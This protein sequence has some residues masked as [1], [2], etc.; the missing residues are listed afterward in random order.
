MIPLDPCSESPEWARSY[1]NLR[2]A[3]QKATNENGYDSHA[4]RTRVHQLFRER[5]GCPPHD[6]QVDVTEAMLLGL[7]SI[8]IAGTG[9]GKTMPFMMPLLL[10]LK[11]KCIIISPLK[12]LQEDQASRFRRMQ[13]SATA[14]N[15]DSWSRE[16]QK[17]LEDNQYQ[18]ILA[19]P[20]MCIK[21]SDFRRT[22]TNSNFKD[23]VAIIIDEAHCIGQWGGDFRTAY[24][25]LAKLRAFFPPH[26]PVLATTATATLQTLRDIRLS[27]GIDAATSFF[28]NLGNDRPNI[29]YHVHRMNSAID[30]EALRPHITREANVSRQDDIP[31]QIIF[32]NAVL[33]SQILTRT[34]RS[35]FPSSLHNSIAYLHSHRSKRAKHQIMEAFRKGKVRILIATEAA[36]MGADIPDI[37]QVIQFGVPSSLAVWTQRAGRAGR[38]ANI[39]ARAILLVEKSMFE[40]TKK[41][42]RKAA[43]PGELEDTFPEELGADEEEGSEVEL[44]AENIESEWKK[45]VED[46][47]RRWIETTG[48]RRDIADTYFHNPRHRP[49]THLC[50]DNCTIMDVDSNAVGA[51]AAE[52]RP[53]TPLPT[54][55]ACNSVHST[56]SKSAN[57]NGKR[58]MTLSQSQARHRQGEHLK[59]ARIALQNWR[60]NVVHHHYTPGPFTVAAFMPD[61]VIKL[62]ASLLTIKSVDDM[63]DNIQ[64]AFVDRHGDDVLGVL[65]RVDSFVQDRRE[66]AKR[67][68]A[69]ERS[70]ATEARQQE[71]RIVEDRRREEKRREREMAQQAK[72]ADKENRKQQKVAAR[73]AAAALKAALKPPP[74]RARR[75]PLA[76]T[77]V[78]NSSDSTISESL[79]SSDSTLF[80]STS[81]APGAFINYQLPTPL[82]HPRPQARPRTRQKPPGSSSPLPPLPV[83]V[84][85]P[86]SPLSIPS[87]SLPTLCP[88]P[89]R[90]RPK[91][92][93]A[94][95][96]MLP[97]LPSLA[98]TLLGSAVEPASCSTSDESMP[99]SSM[100]ERSN[101][102]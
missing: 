81:P 82:S 44:D 14:V 19:S 84:P 99:Q 78:L 35:W 9:A 56:P 79:P 77:S 49:P 69:A 50:C 55:D 91:P 66:S 85:S 11:S 10:D 20:E 13:I 25:E 86:P 21:H 43:P 68:K 8:V 97:P 24:A 98:S 31:K 72:L 65:R 51:I 27:L 41:R 59:E 94:T 76:G 52:D 4:T 100:V 26:I 63:R 30:Y 5:F 53:T 83:S 92:R 6:W 45:K 57:A 48:C 67:A 36:G 1:R 88:P 22:L 18:G 75:P 39:N 46:A 62:L 33:M 60:Y 12:V 37:E 70:A 61:S 34:I 80:L 32:V 90:P 29:S 87:S 102:R 7:D 89:P 38:S 40:R 15:G 101:L 71:R 74:K 93:M 96:S 54:H 73:Q 95:R 3:I 42:R 16:L 58:G 17:G 28:L 64:W 2:A 47:L 23:I